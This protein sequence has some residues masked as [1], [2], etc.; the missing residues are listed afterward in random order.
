MPTQK[1][2]VPLMLIW[3]RKSTAD[4]VAHPVA[5]A[6]PTPGI[7]NV[8]K[9]RATLLGNTGNCQMAISY[10]ITNTPDDEGSWDTPIDLTSFT[11]TEGT[12]YGSTWTDISSN[13]TKR[14][15]RFLASAKNSTGTAVE[16]MYVELEIDVRE[17]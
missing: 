13:L 2:T 5:G 16:A 12:T 1:L 4:A 10:Q 17:D 7:K 8:R 14:Y 6:M 9:G 15:V 3:T 11:S